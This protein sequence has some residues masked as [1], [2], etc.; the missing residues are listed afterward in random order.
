MAAGIGR[1]FGRRPPLDDPARSAL[2][3]LLLLPTFE[4]LPLKSVTAQIEFLP[5]GAHVTVTA[6]PSGS[7]ESTLTLAADLRAAGFLAAP[8]LAARMVRDRAHLADLL[9][10]MAAAG[11]T[12]AFVV[13]GDAKE[14]GAFADGL[15]LLRAIAEIGPVPAALGIPCYPDGHAFIADEALLDSL[16]AKLPF[17]SW[18]T[19]QMC[20]DP[21][22]IAGWLTA[23]RGEGIAL[24]AVIGI[25]G[26]TEPHRLIAISARI[27]VRESRRFLAKNLGLF[28]RLARSGGFYRPDGLLADLAPLAA[29]P[30]MRIEGLHVYTFNQ[31][32]A[33]ESWRRTY[34]ARLAADGRS[35]A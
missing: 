22:K 12:R 19:T 31:V 7:Q 33:T 6:S 34:L 4:L 15:A 16:R 25:P 26:V 5:P 35:P 30:A 11:L 9:A 13:G 1:L 23:R 21:A 27:G 18:M 3:R 28:A 8:H 24:P 10:R 14:P 29:D 2:A 17:A 20:F 32:A